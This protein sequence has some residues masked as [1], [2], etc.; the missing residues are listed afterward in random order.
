MKHPIS[1]ICLLLSTLS[2]TAQTPASLRSLSTVTINLVNADDLPYHPGVF[3]HF[4]VLDERPDTARI[5]IHNFVPT[6]GH[7][8]NRQLV[9]RRSAAQ[10]IS[11]YLNTRFAR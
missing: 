7:T 2:G 8:R 10:E 4:E 9:L 5:G 11:D 1:I 3:S 6:L